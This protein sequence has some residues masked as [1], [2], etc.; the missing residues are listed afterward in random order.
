MG[1][2][3]RL[4][5]RMPELD[6]DQDQLLLKIQEVTLAALPQASAR[7]AQ[8]LVDVW[9]ERL[10]GRPVLASRRTDLVDFLR[11][12]AAADAPLDIVSGFPAGNWDGNDLSNHY[13][14]ARLRA[15]VAMIMMLP[16]FYER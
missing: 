4:L 10:I 9:L 3:W 8:A 11:Q 16:E 12:N 5:S 7:S 13:T 6:D 14:P 15:T 2:T 1:Q